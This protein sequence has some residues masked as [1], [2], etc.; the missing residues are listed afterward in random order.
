[1]FVSSLSNRTYQQA[2][3]WTLYIQSSYIV[4]NTIA[5]KHNSHT[6]DLAN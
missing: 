3:A 5:H 2:A 1:M 4:G 6:T